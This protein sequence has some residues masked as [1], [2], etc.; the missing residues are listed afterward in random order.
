MMEISAHTEASLA[1]TVASLERTEASLASILASIACTVPPA[2]MYAAEL[3]K[4]YVHSPIRFCKDLHGE[5][6]GR[7]LDTLPISL[8]I[9]HYNLQ[10]FSATYLYIVEH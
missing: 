2:R 7:I 9:L 6:T 8:Y 3:L 5:R 10:Y 1:F 4:K